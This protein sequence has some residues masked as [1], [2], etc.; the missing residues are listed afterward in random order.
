MISINLLYVLDIIVF[1][2]V[3]YLLYLLLTRKIS[4]G[5]FLIYILVVL[6]VVF[7]ILYFVLDKAAYDSIEE[8]KR[9]SESIHVQA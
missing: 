6:V 4:F 5:R 8:T 1:I 7:L 2:I 3:I 9:S